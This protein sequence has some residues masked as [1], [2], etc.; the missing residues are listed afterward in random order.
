MW[1]ATQHHF[2]Y[3]AGD[4]FEGEA[5]EAEFFD[6]R[7]DHQ[8][9][10]GHDVWIGH[11]AVVLAGRTIG[12]GAVVGAGAVVTKDVEPYTIVAGTPARV[13]R[14]RFSE[15][16][17]DKLMALAWWDWEHDQLQAALADF[18]RLDV[19]AFIERYR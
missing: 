8:V 6:W 10:I 2:V 15:E 4:Y 12:T 18:R 16:I 14:R 11:G 9:T 19:E 3:R 13:I 1:R 5:D 17:E 7:R